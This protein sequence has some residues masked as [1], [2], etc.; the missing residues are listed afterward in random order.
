MGA[1][2]RHF[3]L[4]FSSHR[5]A[6]KETVFVKQ[7]TRDKIFY[8]FC[9]MAL[10]FTLMHNAEVI[11]APFIQSRLLHKKGID[12]LSIK[13]YIKIVLISI[14]QIYMLQAHFQIASL[15]FFICSMLT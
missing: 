15:A 2:T 13:Q 9:K 10:L 8:H 14:R 6:V 4:F 5:G 3:F 1:E 11:Y 12:Y 7:A